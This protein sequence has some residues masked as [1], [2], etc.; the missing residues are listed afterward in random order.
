M[1][2]INYGQ[3]TPKRMITLLKTVGKMGE[4]SRDELLDLFQPKGLIDNQ[5][6]S[7]LVY[8]AAKRLELI[9]ESGVERKMVSLHPDILKNGQ[10]KGVEDFRSLFQSK[11]LGVT[12]ET[13]DEYLLNLVIAWYAVKGFGVVGRSKIE[14]AKDFN[15]EMSS[16]DPGALME[17]GRMFNDTKLNAWMPW[18]SFLGFGWVYKNQ[19]I[20]D[21]HVRIHPVI[22]ENKG[23]E[24]PMY[25]F[26]Q[27]ISTKF[28]ELDR[29]YLFEYCRQQLDLAQTRENK[30][31]L[32]LSTGLRV[33]RENKEIS[34]DRH[35]DSTNVWRLHEASGD[36]ESSVSH[37]KFLE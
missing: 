33:L 10:L 16:K 24:L 36:L 20:Q 27:I 11:L 25:E 2:I 21:A 1:E 4:I 17:E 28:P 26:M 12:N 29:G 7:D 18:A 14:V 15:E 8:S 9:R 23:K 5:Q 19:F 30:I 3:I 22:D 32:M 13:Q 34:L 37:I 6:A 31:S 35:L